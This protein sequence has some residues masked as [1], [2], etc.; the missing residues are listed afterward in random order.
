M[1]FGVLFE[2]ERGRV[3]GGGKSF[4]GVSLAYLPHPRLAWHLP[5]IPWIGGGRV[6][7]ISNGGRVESSDRVTCIETPYSTSGARRVY[8]EPEDIL[9]SLN[10]KRLKKSRE[11]FQKTWCQF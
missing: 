5:Q 4:H 1:V 2:F 10:L 8:F 3:D 9:E 6:G 7:E 11:Q